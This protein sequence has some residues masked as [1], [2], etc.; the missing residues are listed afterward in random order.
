[1]SNWQQ[2]GGDMTWEK[3]GVVL[4]LD[5]PRVR[6][7]RLVRVTPWLEHDKEAAV[8]HGLYLVDEKTVDYD[9]LEAFRS[10]VKQAL[11]STGVRPDEYDELGPKYKAQLLADT[12]GY[13]DSRSVDKLA[14]ALPDAPE[15]IEFWGQPE[16]SA[17]LDEYDQETRREALEANFDTRMTFGVMP[18]MDALEF[19][20]GGE[21][22][23]MEFQGESSLAFEYA[24]TVAGIAGDTSSTEEF[25][26][27]VGALAGAPPL[28]ELAP[29][30]LEST[31]LQRILDEWERR[32]GD[33]DDEST[34]IAAAAQ[35]IASD[36]MSAIGFEWI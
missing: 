20:L 30:A 34:G 18:E 23:E 19:A 22:F 14:E 15:N 25:A 17:N 31:A 8:T 35:T 9:D 3:Y 27:T 33:L 10:E 36:M 11:R 16:T 6:Q 28:S 4:A 29:E 24:T 13:E 2:I 12:S 5:E 21:E 7:V 1:M 26:A 32:Y